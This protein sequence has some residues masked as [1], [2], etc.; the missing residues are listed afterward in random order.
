MVHALEDR[1]SQIKL[2]MANSK[3]RLDKVE[4]YF[5]QVGNDMAELDIG[6]RELQ[7]RMGEV[8]SSAVAA[9]SE[10][11]IFGEVLSVLAELTSKVEKMGT[12]L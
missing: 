9:A 3:D 12:N 7:G 2:P 10:L 6:L 11:L 4:Q 5:E 1:L 8:Q